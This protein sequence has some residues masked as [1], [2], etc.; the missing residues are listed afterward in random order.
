MNRGLGAEEGSSWIFLCG[1]VVGA[2]PLLHLF[3][4]FQPLASTSFL[5]QPRVLQG[6]SSLNKDLVSCAGLHSFSRGNSW[7]FILKIVKI[8]GEN[9][10]RNHCNFCDIHAS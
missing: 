4:K 7:I 3:L 10:P 2:T 5:N 6:S 8:L 9:S 1:R